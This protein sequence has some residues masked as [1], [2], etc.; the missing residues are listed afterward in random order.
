MFLEFLVNFFTPLVLSILL[1][2]PPVGILLTVGGTFLFDAD[3]LVY[4]F[5]NPNIKSFK[6]A[7]DFAK[8]E[9]R[10]H[11]PHLFIFHTVEF[12]TISVFLAI[13]LDN[14]TLKYIVL[15]FLI[16]FGLDI[17]TY[18]FYYKSTKPWLKYLSLVSYLL[19]KQS[20]KV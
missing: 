19:K 16:N 6:N 2:F 5:F 8:T 4:M 3:H 10:S 12:L 9:Y 14:A 11:S 20:A 17:I 15:G 1:G 18:V 7:L 13:V